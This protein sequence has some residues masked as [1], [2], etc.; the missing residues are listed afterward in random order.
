[1][2][3]CVKGEMIGT[4]WWWRYFNG[5]RLATHLYPETLW[6]H[7]QL[8]HLRLPRIESP[9]LRS[10]YPWAEADL[11]TSCVYLRPWELT[12]LRA[13]REPIETT[14]VNLQTTCVYRAWALLNNPGLKLTLYPWTVDS[15][16]IDRTWSHLTVT[17]EPSVFHET[18]PGGR[19]GAGNKQINKYIIYIDCLHNLISF[20]DN[21]FKSE[22][23]F[24]DI[25]LLDN[26]LKT[27]NC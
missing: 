5:T 22:L 12:V 17:E 23:C 18:F 27:H 1:M 11:S 4:W 19:L 24:Y 15:L 8:H 25:I 9:E 14:A 21:L 13:C 26:R 2:S 10:R 7:G 3:P 20:N 16:S 6:P